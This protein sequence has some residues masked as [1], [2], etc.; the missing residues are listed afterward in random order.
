MGGGGGGGG[1]GNDSEEE[2]KLGI[3]EL[4]P[5][6]EPEPEPEPEPQTAP[7]PENADARLESLERSIDKLQ[8]Q[9]DELKP[10][11]DLEERVAALESRAD[12]A[13][14]TAAAQTPGADINSALREE[15][16]G[17]K[18]SEL[19]S[20]AKSM[21][22]PQEQLDE[23]DDADD[24]RAAVIDLIVAHD[25]DSS[26]ATMPQLLEGL[27]ERID[28]LEK[29]QG[30]VGGGDS[31]EN[32]LPPPPANA[33]AGIPSPEVATADEAAMLVHKVQPAAREVHAAAQ[34]EQA[35]ELRVSDEP[36]LPPD[37]AQTGDNDEKH[38]DGGGPSPSAV[39]VTALPEEAESRLAAVEA[40]VKSGAVATELPKDIEGRLAALE[41]KAEAKAAAA[42][43]LP[44]GIADRLAAVES[45]VESQD[46]EGK[47]AAMESA[48]ELSN[49][50]VLEIDDKLGDMMD[51]LML[52]QVSLEKKVVAID[53]RLG[54]LEERFE[55]KV[56]DDIFTQLDADGECPPAY[57]CDNV[58]LY[59]AIGLR[60][61]LL[62]LRAMLTFCVR[63]RVR[64][65]CVY[66]VFCCAFSLVGDGVLTPE[67]IA[68]AATF[69]MGN[70]R[71]Q[72]L[73][74]LQAQAISHQSPP[75]HQMLSRVHEAEPPVSAQR[76]GGGGAGES[77][78][79]SYSSQPGG[80]PG[81]G[82]SR[83]LF[84]TFF[85]WRR[86]KA[87]LRFPP[88]RGRCLNLTHTIGCAAA[89]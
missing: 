41:S 38:D 86:G 58:W 52:K 47:V 56:R 28:A 19:K 5:D 48:V 10:P 51:P 71:R 77:N 67:E 26:D 82:T 81:Q 40:A 16:G 34:E 3:E 20:R 68:A 9:M 65:H 17:M 31:D 63:M 70:A 6:P 42:T 37:S 33:P 24:V 80:H 57:T 22:V 53:A 35:E 30:P 15:L 32:D 83:G 55:K 73:Q 43:A 74:E 69:N 66:C 78:P 60:R 14:E 49:E 84:E 23:A 50:Q 54:S 8:T 88:P 72:S 7:L 27:A 59:C 18:I 76:G 45:K 4:Q 13:E 44:G 21:G 1:S 12:A 46:I 29:S 79:P 11:E 62:G 39:A 87:P 85:C 61:L 75:P 64:M 36:P 2:M 89:V 25:V